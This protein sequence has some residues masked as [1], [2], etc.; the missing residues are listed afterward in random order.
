[1]GGFI[2]RKDVNR[3]KEMGITE[4]FRPNSKIED[5]VTVIQNRASDRTT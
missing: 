2:P 4:V 5:I 3:L 1:V